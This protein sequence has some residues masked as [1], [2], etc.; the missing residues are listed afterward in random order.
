MKQYCLEEYIDSI[1]DFPKK[2]ILFRDILPILRNPEIFKK[3]IDSMSK[4][5]ELVD[6]D[7]L[8]AVDARGFLLGSPL[9]LKLN[10][11]LIVARKPNKLPGKTISKSY[12]LEYGENS[13]SI[14]E[15]AINEFQKFAIIDDL[16]ATG[17]TVNCICELLQEKRKIVSC[18][19]VIIELKEFNAKDK[20]SF[21][22]YSQLI[23]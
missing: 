19:S 15:N 8:I 9:S 20:F 3:L 1:V 13:L 14:Q 12:K 17:G 22:T 4:A 5:K 11:P 10:K 2:G 21:P 7:A 18:L 6:S 16:L 23:Y